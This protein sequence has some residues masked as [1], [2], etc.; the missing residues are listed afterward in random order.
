[1]REGT[2]TFPTREHAARS[3]LATHLYEIDGITGVFFGADFITVTKADDQHWAWLKPPILGA[4]MEHFTSG[5]PLMEDEHTG[6][7]VGTGS[8][9]DETDIGVQEPVSD[10]P[11]ELI[12]QVQKLIEERLYPAVHGS[13]GDMCLRSKRCRTS[14]TPCPSPVSIPREVRPSDGFW[15]SASIRRWPATVPAPTIGLGRSATGVMMIPIPAAGVLRH[16][17]GIE[18]ARAPATIDDVTIGMPLL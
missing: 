6:A 18:A 8:D 2:A 1:M 17:A 13:G 10:T 7:G 5:R 16:I 15:T 14:W 4:I 11:Q 3:P 9:C 12:D